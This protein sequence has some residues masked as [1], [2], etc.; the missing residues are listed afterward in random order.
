MGHAHRVSF[1]TMR[2]RPDLL[3]T[4][5]PAQVAPGEKVRVDVVMTSTAETPCKEVVIQ[6]IGTEKRYKHTVSSNNSSHRVY[7]ERQIC[8][9]EVVHDGF[10]LTPGKHTRKCRF[11]VPPDAPPSFSSS[12]STIEYLLSVRIDI[13]WWPDRRGSFV[14]PVPVPPRPAL[15][16]SP[17]RYTSHPAPVKKALFIEASLA[18]DDLATGES[19]E[20]AVALANVQHHRV[21]RIE[22]HLVTIETPLVKSSAGPTEIGTVKWVLFE[23]KPDEGQS[24]PFA[25]RI[26]PEQVPTFESAFLNVTHQL[27]F[28][29]VIAL[30]SDVVV[31]VPVTV[32]RPAAGDVSPDA[33]PVRLGNARRKANWTKVARKIAAPDV[34]A[35]LP[36]D[37]GTT[38]ENESGSDEMIVRVGGSQVHFA[39]EHRGSDGPFLVGHVQWP[40]IG[41]ELRIAERKWLDM[42]K[43]LAMGGA[44][45]ERFL[46]TAREERQARAFFGDGLKKALL[47]FREAGLDD[48]SAAFASPGSPHTSSGLLEFVQAVLRVVRLVSEASNDALPPLV[49]EPARRSYRAFAKQ[50]QGELT[51]GD[52]SM[53]FVAKGLAMSIR[54]RFEGETALETSIAS[55]VAATKAV[56]AERVTELGKGRSVKPELVDGAIRIWVPLVTDP[57]Q[58]ETEI[59]ALAQ[60]VRAAT[61]D[62]TQAGPYR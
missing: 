46:V 4:L 19:V 43:G 23:G 12:F 20:G 56:T 13:P 44:F 6:L 57:S 49:L 2:S 18:A 28:V 14:V 62:R 50:M 52:M 8:A 17:V 32:H 34:H 58:L 55:P 41:L 54:H 36:D 35:E 45:G 1:G 47:R 9:F 33:R 38:E 10:T 51:R 11:I 31:S 16:T 7:H 3:V 48:D 59:E 53:A 22:A 61:G 42:G 39:A 60:I 27:R 30:G 29:A 24:I 21:R 5:R 26:P 15:A 25:L 40:R 37:T